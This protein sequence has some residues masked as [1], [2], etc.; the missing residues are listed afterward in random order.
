MQTVA[1]FGVPGRG[2]TVTHVIRTEQ[3]T[4]MSDEHRGVCGFRRRD[5]ER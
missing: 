5:L 4:R 1:R 3:L 2:K